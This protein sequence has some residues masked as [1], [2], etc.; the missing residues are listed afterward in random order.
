LTEITDLKRLAEK[1]VNIVSVQNG[2]RIIEC[3]EINKASEESINVFWERVEEL[4]DGNPF[5]FIVDLSQAEPPNAIIRA[6]LHERYN[7]VS[8][9]CVSTQAIIKNNILLKI[10]AKFVMSSIGVKNFR[11][12]K[13]FEEARQRIYSKN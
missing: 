11:T 6:A 3:L 8:D 13:N 1:R 9:K 12:A 4:V 2:E 7:R 5:H 10:A